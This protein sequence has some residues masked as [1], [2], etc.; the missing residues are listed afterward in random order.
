VKGKL[1]HLPFNPYMYWCTQLYE[2]KLRNT[3]KKTLKTI[4]TKSAPVVGRPAKKPAHDVPKALR[5]Y[6]KPKI[7]VFLMGGE[8]CIRNH[9]S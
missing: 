5:N 6:G 3:C 2:K 7:P 8:D 1:H 4:G 9:D